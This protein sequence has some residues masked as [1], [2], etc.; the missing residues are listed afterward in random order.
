MKR[1][2]LLF[3]SLAAAACVSADVLS[4]VDG[5]QQN[6]TID[7]KAQSVSVPFTTNNTWSAKSSADWLSISPSSGEAGPVT[8]KIDVSA[9][10]SFESRSTSVVITAQSMTLT[11][12]VTQSEKSGFVLDGTNFSIGS[13]GGEL[14]IPISS[15]IDYICTVA[16]DCKDWLSVT[17]TKALSNYAITI[18]VAKN[19]SYDNR[20]GK[21]EVSA[22]GQKASFSVTQSA[23]KE[24]IVEPN[25]FEIGSAGGELKIPVKTNIE[26]TCELLEAASQWIEVKTLKTKGLEEYFVVLAVKANTDY[27]SRIGQIKLK[28]ADKESIVTITQGQYDEIIVTTT[29]YEIGSDGGSL[30]VPVQANVEYGVEV[31]SGSEWLRASKAASKALETSNVSISVDANSSYDG[32]VGQVQI[33]GSGKKSIVTI[34]QSR[35]EELIVEVS[36]FELECEGGSIS[37]PIKSNC[38]YNCEVV[39]DASE[40]IE[41]APATRALE[42]STIGLIV[43]P[44][45]S[46]DARAGELK[47][48]YGSR[49]SLVSIKQKAAKHI[50]ASSDYAYLYCEDESFEIALRSNVEV[51]VEPKASWFQL[52]EQKKGEGDKLTLSFSAEKYTLPGMRSA[53]VV[54]SNAAANLQKTIT[55]IQSDT[56]IVQV[57]EDEVFAG[58]VAKYDPATIKKMRIIGR[59][60]EGDVADVAN[61]TKLEYLDME[62]T[63]LKSIPDIHYYNFTGFQ[64]CK[65]LH[66][67][68]LPKQLEHIGYSAFCLVN[69]LTAIDIPD[70]VHTI[71]RS[72]FS[73][74]K[75]L[76]SVN[77]PNHSIDLGDSVFYGCKA[78][79][80]I[81]IPEGVRTI[82]KSAFSGSGLVSVKLPESVVSISD[83]GFINCSNLES[84]NLGNVKR[85]YDSAFAYCSGLKTVTLSEDLT[86]IDAMAFYKCGLVTMYCRA[87]EVPEAKYNFLGER[88]TSATI[89]VPAESVDAYKAANE[90]SKHADRIEGYIFD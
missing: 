50:V 68:I 10:D 33:A 36:E 44:N 31:I 71:E 81:E 79:T 43:K 46:I 63:T 25:S 3:A 48:L 38:E 55:V 30:S 4:L 61:F 39:G 88:K 34:S 67:I 76:A 53:Q 51:S 77:L 13:D 73:A 54:F 82:P 90:W 28:A 20:V 15:N 58:K 87:V 8:L 37:I 16:D 27:S 17:K 22:G 75:S 7:S 80:Y 59:L 70:S 42:S 18:S 21:V 24:L 29:S 69:A 86:L 49:E 60:T 62:E 32:R 41:I 65:Q 72:A 5:Q 84:I 52:I 14:S 26:Y 78:L 2:A 40:W 47:I 23:L 45:T 89:Y 74:C 64:G 1:L 12:N 6:V 57:A 85:I 83:S 35:L 9:N 66:T 11:L 19:S 56:L